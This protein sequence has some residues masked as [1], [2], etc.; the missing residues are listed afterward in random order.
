VGRLVYGPGA[1]AFVHV[2]CAAEILHLG[3]NPTFGCG[4]LR[5]DL[6]D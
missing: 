6:V 4:R 5:V 1:A 2:L 3:R